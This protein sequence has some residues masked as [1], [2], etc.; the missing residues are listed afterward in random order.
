MFTKIRTLIK[1]GWPS[2]TFDLRQRS[3]RTKILLTL[4]GLLIVA[5]AALVGGVKAFLWSE[6]PEFCGTVCHSMYPQWV[7]YQASPHAKVAC[8]QC[9]VGPGV[10][11]FVQSKIDGSRQIREKFQ[12]HLIIAVLGAAEMSIC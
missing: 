6:S 7:R 4:A 10:Q 3:V 8:A 9:H 12:S 2:V 11:S 1:N 5:L